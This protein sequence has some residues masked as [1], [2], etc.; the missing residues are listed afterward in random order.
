[1]KPKIIRWLVL[2]TVLSLALLLIAELSLAQAQIEP[3]LP[4][5]IRPCLPQ[6]VERIELLGQVQQEQEAFY[7][8]GA[9]QNDSYWEL[10]VQT[11]AAGCLLVRGQQDTEPLSA[12]IPLE[13][14]QQL[15]LQRYQRRIEEAGGL[16]AFQQ[17]FTDY[18]TSQPGG[19]TSYLAP[20]N[21]WALQQL[22]VTIPEGTYQIRRPNS[23]PSYEPSPSRSQ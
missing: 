15:V 20:E 1:M 12:Y 19:E 17:G 16:Q 3:T 13:I 14:A 7:L 5:T 8:L 23:S 11:D 18:M 4:E 21:V 2:L 9:F 10:L 22:G 6:S